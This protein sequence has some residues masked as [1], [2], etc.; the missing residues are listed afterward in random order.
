MPP[1]PPAAMDAP[2]APPMAAMPQIAAPDPALPYV[3]TPNPQQENLAN[4]A[5]D[6]HKLREKDARPWGFEGAPPSAEYPEGLA[7]NHPGKLGKLGHF[8]GQISN[9]AGDIFAPAQMA[10]IPGTQLNRTTREGQLAKDID[11]EQGDIATNQG[12]DATTAKTKADTAN[13][14]QT[15]AAAPGK[16]ASEEALR[17]AQIGNLNSEAAQR[18]EPDLARAY[19]HAVNQALKNGQDPAQDPIVQHLSDAIT[20]LQKQPAAGKLQYETTVGA[21]GKPHT[22]GLDETGKKVADEGVHY[23]KPS[24]VN[25]VMAANGNM[26]SLVTAIGEGRAPLPNPRT[27]QGAQILAAVTAKYPNF[28]GSTYSTQEGTRHAATYGK[29]GTTINSLNTVNEH[30]DSAVKNMPANGNY[31]LL[32]T[33]ENAASSAV[34]GNPTGKYAI[35]ADAIAGEWSKMVGG[36]VATESE[37]RH[38][39]QLLDPNASPE[40][41]RQNLTEVRSLTQGKLEG[42]QKQV[43]SGTLPSETPTRNIN[44]LPAGHASSASSK[45]I[46]YKIVGGKLVAQ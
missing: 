37:L 10:M 3:A 26:D 21:D 14:D 15:I 27:A 33:V 18:Q 9:I 17:T 40:Q 30:L 31:N 35:D 44:S 23:E 32:N 20:S 42:I 36:G 25:N 39:Q 34:G 8:F 45:E 13:V 4:N 38:V 2:A 11:T 28:D 43:Q 7:P 19:A 41:M 1:Q 16:E 6:L 22:Y 24:V 46:H 5:S 29:L 12:R